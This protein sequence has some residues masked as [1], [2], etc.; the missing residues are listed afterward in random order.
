M[1]YNKKINDN[2][3]PSFLIQKKTKA[4]DWKGEDGSKKLDPNGND[5]ALTFIL[6]DYKIKLIIHEK[7]MVHS[8]FV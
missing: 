8:D 5:A 1:L 3:F 2:Q 6:S 4:F 7:Y